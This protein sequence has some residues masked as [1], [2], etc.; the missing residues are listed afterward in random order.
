[1]GRNKVMSKERLYIAYGSNLNLPQMASRCPTAKPVGTTELKGHELV[2]RGWK[3]GGV[4]TVEP[5]ADSSVPV[6][7]WSIKPEDETALDQYEGFPRLYTK[8]MI[9]VELDGKTASAMI[10]VMTPGH[11]AAYPSQYYFDVIAEGYKS[12]G[13]DLAVIDVALERTKEIMRQEVVNRFT[14]LGTNQ[15][16]EQGTLELGITE[17]VNDGSLKFI[18]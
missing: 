2:F 12:A 7:V 15:R 6:L 18:M 13:F 14:E 4:A 8:H 17:Q 11:E 1:M 3:R 9:D 16:Y 5:N 10:Y